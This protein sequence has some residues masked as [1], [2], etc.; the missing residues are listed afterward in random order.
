MST[1][2]A[3]AYASNQ[4]RAGSA[5]V[6]AEKVFFE[7]SERFR[8]GEPCP[9]VAPR[10]IENLTDLAL[11]GVAGDEPVDER[12]RVLAFDVVLI[13]RGDIDERR[14]VSNRL[15]LGLAVLL[16]S[17][18]GEI[19]GPVFPMEARIERFGTGVKGCSDRHG[20]FPSRSV[21]VPEPDCPSS[22]VAGIFDQYIVFQIVPQCNIIIHI[23]EA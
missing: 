11:G 14:S 18:G 10:S 1:S 19:A 12:F 5:D 23:M 22:G 20:P 15:V 8:L 6:N 3:T 21:D 4:C 17:D 9:V 7:S 13:K 2:K 16:I